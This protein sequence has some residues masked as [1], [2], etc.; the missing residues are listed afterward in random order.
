MYR[1]S[2]LRVL[3]LKGLRAEEFVGLFKEP[4]GFKVYRGGGG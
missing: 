2:G 4:K 3:G 1:D